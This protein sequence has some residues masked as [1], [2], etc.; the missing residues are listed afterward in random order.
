MPIRAKVVELELPEKALFLITALS[1][2][3]DEELCAEMNNP[4]RL[5]HTA[6]DRNKNTCIGQMGD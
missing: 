6:F 5:R 2:A 1:R 3:I 4:P